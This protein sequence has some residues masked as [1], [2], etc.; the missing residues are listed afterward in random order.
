MKM[1]KKDKSE[2]IKEKILLKELY[3]LRFFMN[4]FERDHGSLNQNLT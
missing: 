1:E 3:R 4:R 2:N